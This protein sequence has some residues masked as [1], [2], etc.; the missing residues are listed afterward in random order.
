MTNNPDKVY[1]LG[2]FG[3][4]IKERVPIEIPPQKY[5]YKYLKTKKTRMGHILSV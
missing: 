4:E 5:D 3:L 1:G 2:D